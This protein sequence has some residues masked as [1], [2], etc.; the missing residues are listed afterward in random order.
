MEEALVCFSSCPRDGCSVPLCSNTDCLFWLFRNS[1]FARST[2]FLTCFRTIV[3]LAESLISS[4]LL[5]VTNENLGDVFFGKLTTKVCCAESELLGLDI[6]RLYFPRYCWNL[7]Q[8]LVFSCIFLLAQEECKRH[9]GFVI[10]MREM[11]HFHIS[12]PH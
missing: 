6:F 2:L 4:G 9:S 5:I 8:E 11:S 3:F 10:Q 1:S 7:S 12:T